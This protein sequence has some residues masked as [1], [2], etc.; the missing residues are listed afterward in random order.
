LEKKDFTIDLRELVIEQF[1]V[2]DTE[3]LL[4]Q[5]ERIKKVGIIKF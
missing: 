1:L 4:F 2:L 5:F 3:E